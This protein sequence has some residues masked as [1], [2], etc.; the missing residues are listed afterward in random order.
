[1]TNRFEWK[2]SFR[3]EILLFVLLIGLATFL[4]LYHLSADPPNSITFSQGLETDP[5]QY[6]IFARD[7]ILNDNWNSFEDNR[8][9]TYQ[10]S[11][12]SLASR[13]VFS[14][15]G[16]GTFQANLVG[17]LLS[18]LSILFFYFIIRKQ[19]GNGTALIAVFFV[20]INYLGIFWGRRPFL[21]N[22]MI[23][24]FLSGLLAVTYA[25]KRVWGHFLFG[26]FLAGSI[27][28]GKI[29]ALSFV[30]VPLGYY[31]FRIFHVKKDTS[32]RDCLMALAGFVTLALIWFFAIYRPNSVA[33]AGYVREQAL[34]LYG[35]PEGLTSLSKFLWK[36]MTF[37]KE[38]DFFDRMP[39]ISYGSALAI[40]LVAGRFLFIR[41]NGADD[42]Q[43]K[44]ESP[45]VDSFLIIMSVWLI[46]TFVGQMIWN[47]QPV[48]YQTVMIFPL[49]ALT[50]LLLAWLRNVPKKLNLSN[51][52]LLFGLV[53]FTVLMIVGYQ[54]TGEILISRDFKFS[55]TGNFWQIC[56]GSAFLATGFYLI[57]FRYRS[58]VINC[59]KYS[60]LIPLIIAS[61][62][63]TSLTVHGL[64][65]V[66]WAE[67]VLYTSRQASR[68]LGQ[69]LSPEAVIS[70]PFGPALVMDNDLDCVIHIFGTSRP[71]TLLFRKYP[72]THLAMEKSNFDAAKNIYPEI[73]EKADKVCYFFLNCRKITIYRI[74]HLTGNEQA[75][76]Y[77]MSDYE[78]SGQFYHLGQQSEGDFY[79]KRFQKLYPDNM[80]GNMQCGYDAF[81]NKKD[82][83]AAVRFFQRAID[84]SPTNYFIHSLLGKTYIA[85]GDS[86]NSDSLRLLGYCA[87]ELAEKYNL[88]Y[89]NF[90]DYEY[91]DTYEENVDDSTVDEEFSPSLD[92]SPG[93]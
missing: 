47:Y 93:L 81:Q 26:F 35:M 92:N 7:A 69:I 76:A 50:A 21:E 45:K 56:L 38:S 37:G 18:L 84:F 12:V 63:G 72:I 16:I 90:A 2:L 85:F 86:L 3:W 65:Y 27:L 23:L 41:E 91:N 88:G 29:I 39:I 6:T 59:R 55:F 71:D 15:F 31:A 4:R 78:I 89:I 1:M 54:I 58:L 14:V 34:G 28:F 36:M 75:S 80:I 46:G 48:R 49:A 73:M 24:L 53:L 44:T 30:A 9:I 52:S 42:E 60:W 17:A 79:L 64:H 25:E 33:V 66:K 8:Y 74:A 43:G 57:S 5:P 68:D 82:Y 22:G 70:G 19:A 10:Y 67:T 77:K 13:A 61:A 20:A 32:I 51:R 40:L 11:L 62:L 87:N 83:E